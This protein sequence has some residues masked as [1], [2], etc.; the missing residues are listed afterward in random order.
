MLSRYCFFSGMIQ[1]P[2]GLRPRSRSASPG[3]GVPLYTCRTRGSEIDRFDVL[4][5]SAATPV[6]WRDTV[7]AQPLPDPHE[8][9]HVAMT[10]DREEEEVGHR[11]RRQPLIR[12]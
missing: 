6:R 4:F 2:F 7:L 3:S 1:S 10:A 9:V 11:R 12:R 5:L 8:R